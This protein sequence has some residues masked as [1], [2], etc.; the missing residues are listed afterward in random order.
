MKHA[1]ARLPL[2]PFN[3]VDHTYY[4]LVHHVFHEVMAIKI[5]GV[6]R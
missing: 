4:S 1:G 6:H 5:V 3:F 2:R